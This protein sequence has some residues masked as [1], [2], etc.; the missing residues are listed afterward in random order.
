M[1]TYKINASRLDRYKVEIDPKVITDSYLKDWSKTFSDVDEEEYCENLTFQAMI[2]G[3]GNFF[4]GYGYVKTY[5]EDHEGNRR[6]KLQYKSGFTE[7]DER[8]YAEGIVLIILEEN[9]VH[10]FESELITT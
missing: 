6:L 7:V 5:Y 1:K 2:R 9:D 3:T 4:E 8:E 10:E